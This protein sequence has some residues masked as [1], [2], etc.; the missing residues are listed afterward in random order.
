MK[1]FTPLILIV[2]A[3]SH[4]SVSQIPTAPQPPPPPVR[5]QGIGPAGSSSAILGEL[6]GGV[7]TNE[8]FGLSLTI[9]DSFVV[10]N[11]KELELLQKVGV[12]L[13]TEDGEKNPSRLEKAIQETAVI[14]GVFR[15]PVGEPNNSAVEIGVLRQPA[16]VTANMALAANASL[17]TGSAGY[18]M[19]RNL[20]EVS[21]GGVKFVGAEFERNI[22]GVNLKQR[23]YVAMRRGY[24][25]LISVVYTTEEGLEA[26]ESLLNGIKFENR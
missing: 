25:I 10:V 9:P 4:A 20:P 8:F 11:Q 3:F 2:F 15:F 5:I 13:L 26:M 6:K 23:S 12:D 18:E 17:L 1:Y 7:Y 19:T 21:F 14:L 24:S 16:G 22:F